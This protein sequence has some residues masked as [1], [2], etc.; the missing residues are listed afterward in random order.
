[1][2]SHEHIEAAGRMVEAEYLSAVKK[3]YLEMY[4]SLSN[5]RFKE[6]EEEEARKA[7]E[8]LQPWSDPSDP[9]P[10]F[11]NDLHATVADQLKLEDYAELEFYTAVGSHLDV[12][13]GIDAFFK[14]KAGDK[15]IVV[16]LDLTTKDYKSNPKADIMIYVPKEY[17]VSRTENPKEYADIIK[18]AAEKISKK[19][20][21]YFN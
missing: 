12:K 1:M 14:F 11:A 19:I 8:G 6:T 7:V 9:D 21:N 3:K 18:E 2:L 17:I 13:F 16:S 5:L 15:E 20:K 10:D 4:G